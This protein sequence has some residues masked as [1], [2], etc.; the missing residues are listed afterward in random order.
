MTELGG[1]LMWWSTGFV[2]LVDLY[3]ISQMKF[4]YHPP[5]LA[6]MRTGDK[7]H[8][9]VS[10]HIFLQ[11]LPGPGHVNWASLAA[12]CLVPSWH[13][14][15]LTQL[16]MVSSWWAQLHLYRQMKWLIFLVAA[17][18]LPCKLVQCPVLECALVYLCRNVACQLATGRGTQENH[19]SGQ[20]QGYSSSSALGLY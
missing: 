12:S 13:L 6:V 10:T 4:L 14:A 7:K 15:L 18:C 16:C 20:Q 9:N 8:D 11:Q 2:S 5:S 17:T 3:G 1:Y 19:S